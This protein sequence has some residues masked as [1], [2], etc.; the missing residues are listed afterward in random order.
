MTMLA[1]TLAVF[2]AVALLLDKGD[3]RRLLT[4]LRRN[5]ARP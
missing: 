3:L 2:G 5:E 1:I 4:R